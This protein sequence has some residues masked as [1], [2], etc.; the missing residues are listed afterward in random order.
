MQRREP[1]T[2]S[3][4][5]G[6]LHGQLDKAQ[7]GIQWRYR[8]SLNFQLCWRMTHLLHLLKYYGHNQVLEIPTIVH[9]NKYTIGG[10]R[11]IKLVFS[12]V[13]SV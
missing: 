12:L 11:T 10:Q 9:S 6:M 3:H 5:R 4:G 13:F 8:Q 2:L 7:C 1:K